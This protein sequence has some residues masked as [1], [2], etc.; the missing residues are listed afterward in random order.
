MSDEIILS[1][2]TCFGNRRFVYIIHADC[3]AKQKCLNMQ[4][5]NPLQKYLNIF[6]NCILNYKL[7]RLKTS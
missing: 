3:Y 6:V 1:F 5:I 7:F 2:Q 4:S